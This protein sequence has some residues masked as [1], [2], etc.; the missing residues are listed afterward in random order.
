MKALLHVIG[1]VVVVPYVALALF[2]LA[3]G[4]AARTKGLFALFDIAW[5]NL[6]WFVGWGLYAVPVLWICLVATGFVPELQ[7]ASSLCLCL[8]AVTS[9]LVVV[10]LPATK[11][12]VGEL[13]FLLPCVAVAVTSAWLFIRLGVHS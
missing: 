11:A 12:G 8:L 5:R 3:V 13:I 2:F 6:D 9:F 4:E 7:R 10:I 1:S